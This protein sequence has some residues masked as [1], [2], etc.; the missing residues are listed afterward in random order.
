MH[1]N[2][3]CIKVLLWIGAALFLLCFLGSTIAPE[4]VLPAVG[5]SNYHDFI[6]RLYG[7]FQLSWAILFLF[8]LKD[9]ERNLAIITGVLVAVFFV[10][11]QLAVIKSGGY[12]MFNAA[13]LLAY[14][15]LLF[16]CKPRPARSG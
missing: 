11:Y 1:K 2:P 3:V 16:L 10:V 7:I 9:V 4:H 5:L 8:A 14:A 6:I 12:L 13:F 15:V